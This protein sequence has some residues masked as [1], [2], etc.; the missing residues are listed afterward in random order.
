M[1]GHT[2][3]SNLFRESESDVESFLSLS[4]QI[5]LYSSA[6]INMYDMSVTRWVCHLSSFWLKARASS[7]MCD[8]SVTRR[9]C[10]R[11]MSWSNAPTRLNI[12]A[13]SV[14][15]PVYHRPDVPIERMLMARRV[16][17]RPMSWL[18]V[19]WW[20]G[21]SATRGSLYIWRSL[22]VGIDDHIYI[23]IQLL[24]LT[25]YSWTLWSYIYIYI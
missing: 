22:Q 6:P 21:G 3:E 7:N 23:Y 14:T 5:Y 1:Y 24:A 17:H 4:I 12:C 25:R 18:K 16:C 9:V 8:M 2:I 11:P 10:H 20:R 13:M 19:C 15:V